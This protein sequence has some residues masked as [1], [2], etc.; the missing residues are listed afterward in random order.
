M[1]AIQ[2]ERLTGERLLGLLPELAARH[3]AVEPFAV[4]LEAR[5]YAFDDGRQARAVGFTCGDEVEAR[6]SAAK[7]SR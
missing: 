4:E 5:G 1:S 3:V 7:A 2:L 6:H